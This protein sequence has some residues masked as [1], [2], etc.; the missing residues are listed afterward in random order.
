MSLSSALLHSSMISLMTTLASLALPS[1]GHIRRR[2]VQRCGSN[3]ARTFSWTLW[4]P[5]DR[6]ASKLGRTPFLGDP[7][8]IWE[9]ENDHKP[10]I[11]L[12]SITSHRTVTWNVY[13]FSVTACW[14]LGIL[15]AGHVI[16]NVEMLRRLT[17]T[18]L[19]SI[20]T[21][22]SQ[23]RSS[24]HCAARY[25]RLLPDVIPKAS[26]ATLPRGGSCNDLDGNFQP[27]DVEVPPVIQSSTTFLE[28]IPLEA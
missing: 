28:R 18:H 20:W 11:D 6:G 5:M 24:P 1:S 2:M 23:V 14:L 21:S 27:K 13:T 25:K 12:I 4:V 8:K 15:T 10:I 22:K 16:R 3:T 7:K 26:Q 19:P 9:N 17:G